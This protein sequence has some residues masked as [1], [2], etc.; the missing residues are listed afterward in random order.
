MFDYTICNVRLTNFRDEP[1]RDERPSYIHGIGS[2]P[3]I[4]ATI[5]QLLE[6]AANRHPDREAFIVSHQRVRLT[7]QQLLQQV[8]FVCPITKSILFAIVSMVKVSSTKK[9]SVE[10]L[11]S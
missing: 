6:Q 2:M 3:L 9:K 11:Q 5:G 10:Y 8:S 4:G 7:F 1:V